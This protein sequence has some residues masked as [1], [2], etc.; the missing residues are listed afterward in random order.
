VCINDVHLSEKKYQKL[1]SAILNA[2]E[3]AFPEKSRFEL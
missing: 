3:M 2:F 1:H